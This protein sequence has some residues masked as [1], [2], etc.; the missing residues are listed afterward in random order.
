[1][2]AALRHQL[3]IVLAASA[4]FF[5]NL[6]SAGLWDE[7]EPLYAAIALDMFER[8]DWVVPRY[9]GEMFPE[10][11]PLAYWL[12]IAGYA[13]F[14]VGEMG[15]RFWSAVF[16]VA[17]ALVTYH[18]GRRLFK[19]SVGLW[20]GLAT[21]TTLIFTVSARAATT[22]SVFV[23]FTAL[24]MLLFVAAGMVPSSRA[25]VEP[26]PRSGP[27][28]KHPPRPSGLF[29]SGPWLA[30]VLLYAC[31]GLAVLTKGPIGVL[32]PVAMLGFFLLVSAHL[33]SGD[34]WW[35]DRRAGLLARYPKAHRG[36]HLQPGWQARTLWAMLV[37]WG[38]G[39]VALLRPFRPGRLLRAAW[40][41][42]PLTAVVVVGAIAVPWYVM[43][44]M[45]TDGE[46]LTRFLY[47]QNVGRALQPMQGHSGPF[48]YYVPAIL[49]GF[50]PWS[51]FMGPSLVELFRG[52]GRRSPWRMEHWFVA[53]WVF[54][55]V[56]AWSVPSTKLP[57]YVLTA[58]P[59]LALMT[60]WFID[61]WI[62][63]PAAIHPGWI[64]SGVTTTVL[65]G[66]GLMVA[67]PIVA[68]ILAPGEELLGLLG[69]VL[70]A[71]A[72]VFSALFRRGRRLAA[73]VSF[74]VTS[75]VFLA[76]IFGVAA[77]R[78]DRFQTA[79]PML[80]ELRAACPGDC[81]LAGYH[82][83]RESFVFYARQPIASCEKPDE[84]R[85][86]LD[87]SERPYVFATSKQEEELRAAF[88][89]ELEV[90]ARRPRFLR[91]GEILLLARRRSDPTA[92]VAVSGDATRR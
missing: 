33:R 35:Q 8:G 41:L 38:V 10:K 46:F 62:A 36:E 80:A 18:L 9:N 78:I 69:L 23:F 52:C 68:M 48:W 64:R 63:E 66:A 88:G 75:V 47:E 54:C 90:V 76:S 92:T 25:E 12:M 27:R 71:G 32:L 77:V 51:V 85:R 84:L 44:G 58:Y 89:E 61:R 65:V 43:V 13:M 57:H 26:E 1:M 34:T 14:G 22:D 87:E 70:I 73:V 82:F 53:S 3:W 50:F 45:R 83:V 7:D 67:F 15:A 20:A 6:G 37:T 49:I 19:P 42:R 29:K 24:A 17:T 31:L 55:F 81:Q 16:G 5:L 2:P 56:G 91:R 74:A 21:A 28:A 30:F 72:L 79:R 59:A 11:P 60:G 39:I 86:F 40:Q 4:V